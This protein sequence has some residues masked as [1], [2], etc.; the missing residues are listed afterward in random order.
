MMIVDC[1]TCPVRD[2]H[3]ADCVVTAFAALPHH[4]ADRAPV[5]VPVPQV[6]RPL[7]AA[8]A[9]GRADATSSSASSSDGAV[10]EPPVVSDDAVTVPIDRAE[11]RAIAVLIGAGLIDHETANHARAELAPGHPLRTGH[12]VRRAM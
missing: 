6:R 12:G 8:P 11:R 5:A 1:Q 9:A 10:P 3:C 4:A 7:A 2:V